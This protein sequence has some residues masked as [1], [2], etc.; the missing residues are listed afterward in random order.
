VA[1]DDAYNVVKEHHKNNRPPKA[2]TSK[3]LKSTSNSSDV[4]ADAMSNSSA[5]DGSDSAE[6]SEDNS[7]APCHSKTPYRFPRI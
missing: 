7:Q 1:D 3:S 5:S 2:S 4:D 6:E